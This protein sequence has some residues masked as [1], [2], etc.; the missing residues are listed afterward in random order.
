MT[1]LNGTQVRFET[2]FLILRTDQDVF[3]YKS[4][5]LSNEEKQSEND[6]EKLLSVI[7]G[8]PDMVNSELKIDQQLSL[9]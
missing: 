7:F 3:T 2:P 5:F 6:N 1:N 4:Y 8:Y 9:I